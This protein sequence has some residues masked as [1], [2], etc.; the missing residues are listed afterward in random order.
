M[1]I[2]AD[3]SLRDVAFEVCTAL[4]RSGTTAVLSGGAAAT[5]YAP[6]AIQSFDLDFVLTLHGASAR[7]AEALESLGYSLQGQHY[8]H[9]SNPFLLEFPPGPLAIGDEL[10][11]QWPTLRERGRVLHVILATDSCR[12]RL[13]AFY[14]FGDRSALEQALAIQRAQPDSVDLHLV[15]EWSDREGHAERCAEFLAAVK[16]GA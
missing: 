9:A 3:T 15:R 11:T 14:H 6:E 12:D 2:G 1:S 8:E 16:A 13:A 7:A 10:I 5:L 4:D